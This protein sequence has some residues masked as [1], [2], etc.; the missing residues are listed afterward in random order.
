MVVRHGFR[1]KNK[2]SKFKV[3]GWRYG[4]VVFKVGGWRYGLMVFKVGGVY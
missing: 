4:L 3:G 1:V 2:N